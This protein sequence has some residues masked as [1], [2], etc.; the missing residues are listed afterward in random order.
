MIK[1][2]IIALILVVIV[3]G[4]LVGFNLFR[5]NAIKQFFATMKQ[6]PVVVSAVD[7][8]P[9]TWTPGVE[10]FGSVRAAQGVDVPV[11]AAGAVKSVLFK[12]NDQ[13]TAGQV[14]VQIDD[15]IERA[16]LPG[17][18]SAVVLDESALTRARSLAKG[19]FDTAVSVDQAETQLDAARSQLA[20]IQATLDQKAI[21]APFGGIIGIARVDVGQWAQIGTIVATLQKLDEMKVDFTLPEQSVPSLRIGEPVIFGE[22]EDQ[23]TYKG[24]VIGID[25]KV[26]P[27]TRL[28]SVQAILENPAGKLR[29]GQFI[30]VRVELPSEDNVI[31]VPQT[32]VT[33]SLYGD[34]VFKID[35][36]PPPAPGTAPA[37]PAPAPAA[38]SAPAATPA[39][40]ALVAHQIFVKTG[41]RNG[42]LIELVSGVSPGDKIVTAGQNRLSNGTSVTIDNTIDPA[43][44]AANQ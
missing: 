41:R 19:G 20:R 36:A 26:D 8:T 9:V 37:A 15:S 1:R 42:G 27:Q 10:A 30:R 35:P 40:P 4:G 16:D 33:T 23:M 43:K 5:A 32:T 14:L 25:P 18:Q 11:Q 28:V 44:I 38:G 13:V 29:P 22:T 3:C 21:K 2:F 39:G 17:A 6:P 12:A 24:Q 31:A 7:V 34:F